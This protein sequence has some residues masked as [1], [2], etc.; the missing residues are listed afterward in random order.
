MP[1]QDTPILPFEGFLKQLIKEKFLIGT[2]EYTEFT[3]IFLSFF[4][5]PDEKDRERSIRQFKYYL[6]PL[7]C[8]NEDQQAKFYQLYDNYFITGKGGV[9]IQPQVVK[10]RQW[11]KIV[12]IALA[13]L[14]LFSA[15]YGIYKRTISRPRTITYTLQP[16]TTLT[17]N[18]SLWVN[19]P[20]RF[21][22]SP[23]V[24]TGQMDTPVAEWAFGDGSQ[25]ATGELVSHRY[26]RC[27]LYTVRLDLKEKA[28]GHVLKSATDSFTVYPSASLKRE[29]QGDIHPGD[30]VTIRATP[31]DSIYR[32]KNFQWVVANITTNGPA[33][34]I[35]NGNTILNYP[36]RDT[37]VY[38]VWFLPL[39]GLC[40]SGPSMSFTA[41]GLK[42]DFVVYMQPI[43][44]AIA[45]QIHVNRYWGTGLILLIVC[46]ILIARY[47]YKKSRTTS[48]VLP[49][50]KED[51]SGMDAP[52]EIPF[53]PRN[54]RIIRLQNLSRSSNQLIQRTES[55]ITFL[56]V[57]KTIAGAVRNY[58]YVDPQYSFRSKDK[59]YLVLID[60]S[61]EAGSQYISLFGYLAKMLVAD[62]VSLSYYYYYDSPD[63]LLAENSSVHTDLSTLRDRH[64]DS[65]LIVFGNGYNLLSRDKHEVDPDKRRLLDFW[66]RKILVT[67]VPSM[68][69]SGSEY[70]LTKSFNLVPADAEGLLYLIKFISEEL[71]GS[72][73]LR[74]K[75][76]N[77]YESTYA[78]VDTIDG[79]QLYLND[80]DLYL[81]LCALAVYPS[82]RW[83]VLIELGRTVL[84]ARNKQS[85]LNYE[86]LLK[87]ARIRWIREGA[88]PL[89]LRLELLKD[90]PVEIELSARRTLLNLMTESD[91]IITPQSFTYE[92]KAM[93]IFT[94]SFI[95]YANSREKNSIYEEE[96]EKF[97]SLWTN[98]KS[99]D[100]TVR[101]YLENPTGAWTTPVNS[102]D[103]NKKNI[104]VDEFIRERADPKIPRLCWWL[105]GSAGFFLLLL[106]FLILAAS[107]VTRL[108]V[109]HWL[110]LVKE[111]YQSLADLTFKSD[112]NRCMGKDSLRPSNIEP[113]IDPATNISIQ[114]KGDTVFYSFDT[115]AG[116]FI[117]TIRNVDP[118]LVENG[119]LRFYQRGTGLPVR[120]EK[121][122]RGQLYKSYRIRFVGS[123]CNSGSPPGVVP[124]TVYTQFD[125]ALSRD[126]VEVFRS[127][128]NNELFTATPL[129]GRAYK[130]PN[131]I[132]YFNDSMKSK[133]LAL[134]KIVEDCFGIRLKIARSALPEQND[135][136]EIWLSDLHK[137]APVLAQSDGQ[138]YQIFK[139]ARDYLDHRNMSEALRH[140]D[141]YIIGFPNGK[142]LLQAYDYKGSIYR[143]TG[144]YTNAIAAYL[145]VA[146][147]DSDTTGQIALATIADIYL[148]QLQDYANAEKYYF[149]LKNMASL[150]NNKILG[151][152]GLL[153]TQYQLQEWVA[154]ASNARELLANR[155]FNPGNAQLAVLV[156][157]KYYQSLNRLDSALYFF[158]TSSSPNGTIYAADARY[159]VAY[160][161]FLEGDLKNSETSALEMIKSSSYYKEW[162]TKAYLLLGDIYFKQKDYIK[163][164]ATFQSIVD[165]S[166]IPAMSKLA[167]QK[168]DSVIAEEKKNGTKK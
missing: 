167:Q 81:W 153:I 100:I 25:P 44:P 119:K 15:G 73:S 127:C 66:M 35:R 26:T 14:L 47:I 69:W 70:I 76:W 158:K 113:V 112:S 10:P 116:Q 41:K 139:T 9:T 87:L 154:A 141:T 49:V 147:R 98:G 92:E 59:D 149:R 143:S 31:V 33:D 124:T 24:V 64:Y 122:G 120:V 34:T 137:N 104:P 166:K 89:G 36:V 79:L 57:K 58:G 7:V 74:I 39:K 18:D 160:I 16:I 46:L 133:A 152:Q 75:E 71:P 108:P 132:R 12:F 85:K 129:E 28:T 110:D 123:Q 45:K 162:V 165:N 32:N 27:G 111:D 97:L 145:Y 117:S 86:S 62:N 6:S 42:E 125:P 146:D 121:V 103:R 4:E 93:Q 135:T 90:L 128:I 159:S 148:Y 43:G 1:G 142:R 63:R 138:E 60:G 17:P 140:F 150:E 8:K 11:K 38:R 22:L 161:L 19:Y 48:R 78:A 77:T 115:R 54:Q 168:L 101:S 53:L 95:L 114:K 151:I 13:A 109:N 134:Q 156:L 52:F 91:K 130:G 94:D 37:G 67:P 83:E 144:D 99:N 55:N 65:T 155:N 107:P 157:G 51:F 102:Y 20:L 126:S 82:I 163:A 21:T 50:L 56:N 80:S 29:G 61:K 136:L 3:A 106:I 5:K 118:T 72:A 84:A 40:T 105:G 2:Q 68:D 88:F 164:K 131:D 96:A 23:I 30:G